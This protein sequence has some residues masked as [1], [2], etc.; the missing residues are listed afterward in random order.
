ME[1]YSYSKQNYFLEPYWTIV[2]VINLLPLSSN[3]TLHLL[4]CNNGPWKIFLPCQLAWYQA[5]SE[6]SPRRTLEEK[7]IFLFL[8]LGCSSRQVPIVGTFLQLQPPVA[9]SGQ[10]H[11][12]F[13]C[14]HL[15]LAS[16]WKALQQSV[17]SLA[18]LCEWLSP[19]ILSK[20]SRREL[21][22]HPVNPG[23]A[24]SNEIWIRG[25]D[26]FQ[27]CPFLGFCISAQGTVAPVTALPLSSLLV[28]PLCL[29]SPVTVN[30]S[31]YQTFY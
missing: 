17:M 30:N 12:E 5:L 16:P 18:T 19:H 25:G 8:A 2:L 4:L 3:F 21:L 20:C 24:L 10:Q 6:E 27:I 31:L 22:C 7:G 28:N 11:M 15:P 9:A 23:C 13:L 1:K 14:G 29:Q 26:L